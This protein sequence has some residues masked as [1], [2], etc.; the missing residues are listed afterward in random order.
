MTS[1]DDLILA[2]RGQQVG[3]SVPIEYWRAGKTQTV[4]VDA[5]S[6]QGVTQ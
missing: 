5:R 1:A 4:Q 3:K 2:I 6:D